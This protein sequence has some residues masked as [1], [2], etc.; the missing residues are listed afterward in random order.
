MSKPLVSLIAVLGCI[1]L[2]ATGAD[3]VQSKCSS[4]KF[5]GTGKKAFKRANCYAKAVRKGEG[6]DSE[7]L[8][9]VSGKFS[10]GFDKAETQGDCLTM[11]D[12]S[13]I[14]TEVD[15]FVDQVR[16]TVN[17]QAAGPSK[18]DS[19]KIKFTGK[20]AYAKAKCY[21]KALSR[22]APLDGTCISK[23]EEKFGIKIAS[24]EAGDDCTNTGQTNAL[25]IR[26]S[27]RE[28]AVRVA[29]RGVRFAVRVSAG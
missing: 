29:E 14:E 6:V 8:T 4:L 19:K 12:T 17:G 1:V 15:T 2:V 27:Q 5:K 26:R 28:H 25:G 23:A 18:C 20:K 9:K 11:S 7:C 21:A 16:T 13:G 22:N 3:A 24:A 10:D